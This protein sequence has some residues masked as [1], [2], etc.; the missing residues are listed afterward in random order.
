MTQARAFVAQRRS[1]AASTAPNAKSMLTKGGKTAVHAKLPLELVRLPMTK[2]MP[3][4]KNAHLAA[5]NSIAL[6]RKPAPASSLPAGANGKTT[7]LPDDVIAAMRQFDDRAVLVTGGSGS[8]GRRFVDTLLRHSRAR[9]IVV[10]SRDE[11]KQYEMQ[12]TARAARHATGCASS[13]A[14][15]ATATGWSWP[16]ATSISSSTRRR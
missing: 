9:R 2:A 8:F 13:S 16:R 4:V 6:L 7:P 12:Q 5:Q 10:F 15:C 3:K 1:S 11:Y 14:T